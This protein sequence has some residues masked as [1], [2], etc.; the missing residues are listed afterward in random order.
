MSSL[1][2][3]DQDA[4]AQQE[5]MHRLKLLLQIKNVLVKDLNRVS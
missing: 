1:R 5:V 2:Q 4:E 3:K